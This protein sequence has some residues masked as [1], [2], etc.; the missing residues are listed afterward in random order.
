MSYVTN[1]SK[2]TRR[3]YP[4]HL[5]AQYVINQIDTLQLCSQ[6]V[7]KKMGYPLKH[8]IPACERLRH[9]LSSRFLGLDGSYID[10]YFTADEFLSKLFEVI[11]IPYQPFAEDIAQIKHDLVHYPYL[12]PTC[13]L[14]ADI[15][16]E[17]SGANWISHGN[18]LRL[19]HILLPDNFVK[20]N[21]AERA[22]IVEE[23]IIEHYQKYAGAL[24]YEGM[25][26]GY[27]LSVEQNNE[28]VKSVA[29]G[30]PKSSDV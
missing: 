28:V 3:Y 30:L 18:V 16:F 4:H 21:E 24:P 15:D 23:A 5:L 20:L 26:K 2:Y 29:Y 17:F 19:A 13:R 27:R 22:S 6:D 14:Q 12:P 9:V 25:I 7:I 10:K 1:Q 11:D 8:T